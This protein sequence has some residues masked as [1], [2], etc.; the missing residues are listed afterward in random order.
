MNSDIALLA[1]AQAMATHALHRQNLIAENIANADTPGYKARDIRP[2]S[3]ESHPSEAP[4]ALRSTR[5]GHVAGLT[6]G[7]STV[8]G[9]LD[10]S[11][12]PSPNGNTVS[13]DREMVK[14]AELRQ[15]YEMA[16]GIY[17][18]SMNILRAS[19]GR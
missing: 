14:A 1:Q 11:A 16:I 3:L 7:S 4:L 19:L 6:A 17:R 18:K 13:L 9:S 10:K 15:Q 12:E 2:F 5:G 8:L